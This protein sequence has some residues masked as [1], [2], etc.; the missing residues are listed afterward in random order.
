[1]ILLTLKAV[2]RFSNAGYNKLWF[3]WTGIYNAKKYPMDLNSLKNFRRNYLKD[4]LIQNPN[5]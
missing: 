4:D 3:Y 1:M 2:L 5:F